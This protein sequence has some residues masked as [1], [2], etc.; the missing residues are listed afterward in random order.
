M[1][2]EIDGR[3]HSLH[4]QSRRPAPRKAKPHLSSRKID[5]VDARVTLSH[6]RTDLG[7]CLDLGASPQ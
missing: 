4:L 2:R 3:K 7:G 5:Q 6:N 1:N